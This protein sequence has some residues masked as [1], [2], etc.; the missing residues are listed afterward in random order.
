GTLLPGET[1]TTSFSFKSADAGIFSDCWR[2]ETAPAAAF[3]LSA[4]P[5]PLPPLSTTAAD[6]KNVVP[7]DDRNLGNHAQRA[8]ESSVVVEEIVREVVRGVRT[9]VREEEVRK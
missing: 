6:S 9:P 4:P 5:L 7:N 3:V 1:A 2:L 8:V